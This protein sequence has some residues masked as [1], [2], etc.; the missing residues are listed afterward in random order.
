MTLPLSVYRLATRLLE[1][2]APGLLKRR[3]GGGKEDRER[4]NERLGY[5]ALSRPFGPLVWIH[6]ASVGETVSAL[7]LVKRL[8]RERSDLHVLVTSGTTTS[9]EILGA[10][11]PDR[12]FHQYA[13][14]DGPAAVARFL[15]HW[16]PDLLILIEGELWPNLLNQAK[17]R[18]IRL[19]LISARMTQSTADGWRWA[20]GTAR[21]LL[22]GFDVI[23]S[24]D[25][26]TRARLEGL[27]IHDA[28]LANLKLVGEPLTGSIEALQ[29]LKN[30]V[31]GRRVVVSAS[32]HPGEEVIVDQA[33]TGLPGRPLH[34][35]APRHPARGDSIEAERSLAG[36]VVTRR[37]R[38]EAITDQT[39]VYLADTLGELGLFFRLGDVI[40][41]GGG[42]AE[43]VNGHNPLEPARLG[44]AVLSGPSVANWESVYS[45]LSAIE[46]VRLA[47]AAD[48]AEALADR[49]GDPEGTAEMG[50]RARR[51]ADGQDAVLDDL[52]TH[53]KPLVPQ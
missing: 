5:P 9:A 50:A 43:G 19:A 4:I 48:V 38:G 41:M 42:W 35:I 49:L 10:R 47:E 36:R 40:V 32:T 21:R 29:H 13:P 8:L 44:Q 23:L 15:D 51:F 28:G 7:P 20:R 33:V 27:G 30:A 52:W 16:R 24:Q 11:L 39:D 3:A 14:V 1:P 25:A 2:L 12:A 53:L 34:L 45:A 37:S 22:A 6:G 18:G 31:A 26:A 17:A 46:A